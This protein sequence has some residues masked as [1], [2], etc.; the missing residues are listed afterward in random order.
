[1][2]LVV[3]GT[4]AFDSIITPDAREDDILGGSATHFAMSSAFHT[5]THLV[6]AVGE[7]FPEDRRELLAGAGIDLE[8]LDIVKGGKTFRWEGKYHEN[9]N[10]RE[11]LSVE[12][13]VFEHFDPVLPASYRKAPFLFLANG[14]PKTQASVLDQA[15]GK[16]FVMADTMDLW[17]QTAHSDLENLIR[18]I[19]GLVLNDEEAAL[20]SEEDQVV[21]AG[22]KIREKYELRY[23]VIKKGEHGC[24]IFHSGGEAALPAVPMAT[25][26]DPTGAGDSF[27]GGLMGYLAQAGATDLEHFKRGVAWGTVMASFCCEGFG[28]KG[29]VGLE[30]ASIQKRFASYREMLNVGA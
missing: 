16:P 3:V 10:T 21:T 26:V 25:V 1:M 28:V 5:K 8:G 19:D 17:I 2:S 29:M 20:L 22:R 27:A 12:L 4:V 15:E 7:D 30:P 23:L 14:V 24:I 18:R 6:G 13:N 9:M 11:T